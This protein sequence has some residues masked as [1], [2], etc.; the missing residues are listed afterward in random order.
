VVY[1]GSYEGCGCGFNFGREYP[2]VEDD[3]EH[4]TA[5]RE[6]VAELVRFVRESRVREIF[7]CE[8][9]DESKPTVQERTVTPDRLASPDFFFRERELLKIDHD[10]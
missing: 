7:S 8:F 9:D 3:A 6:S 4:S 5:A 1:A 2:D 10:G